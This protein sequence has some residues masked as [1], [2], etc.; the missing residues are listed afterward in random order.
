MEQK[1]KLRNKHTHIWSIN[2]QEYTM[3][4]SVASASG[5]G[6]LYVKEWN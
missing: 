3:K 2:L 6:Q 5:A 4:K 1:R